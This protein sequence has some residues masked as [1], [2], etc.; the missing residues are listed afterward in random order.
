[1]T[2]RPTRRGAL[3]LAL[4]ALGAALGCESV[5]GADFGDVKRVEC[6]HAAPPARPDVTNAGGD[7]E[8]LVAITKVDLGDRDLADG[9]PAYKTIGFDLDGVCANQGQRPSCAPYAWAGSDPTNGLDGR[10][11]STG[12]LMHA[13]VDFFGIAPFTSQS[14]SNGVM[15][16]TIAPVGVVR[17]RGYNRR[18]VDDA[19]EVDW[20]LAEPKGAPPKLD[21]TDEWPLWDG[22]IDG[23]APPAPEAFPSSRF[24]DAHA[25]VR[26]YKV[27][28]RLPPKTPLKISNV[29]FPIDDIILVIDLFAGAPETKDDW[30]VVGG[31][32]AGHLR[33]TEIF[34]QMPL[35]T[36]AFKLGRI[37]KT[38]PSYPLVKKY[39]CAFVQA[40][41]DGRNEPDA[42]CDALTFGIRFEAAVVKPGTL[43]PDAPFAPC[44]PDTDPATDTCTIPISSK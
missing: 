33:A 5:I 4:V 6:T 8:I 26:D 13:E 14:I 9:T 38:D 21:G 12:A 28:A 37:C 3:G 22:T 42:P 19:V 43:G 41:A 29:P 11:N 35:M 7:G 27:V 15:N 39:F 18:V 30:K 17:I 40:H 24:R 10:D 16:G 44:S 36:Q 32:I 31:T 1:L 20:Y 2:A 34:R 23:P 25:Y